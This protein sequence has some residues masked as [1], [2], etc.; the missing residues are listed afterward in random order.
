VNYDELAASLIK[1][2]KDST[3]SG[4]KLLDSQRDN[5]FA[6][7]NNAAAAEGTLYSTSGADQRSRYN[8]AKYLPQQAKLRS[9]EQTQEFKITGNLLDTKNKIDAMN[10]AAKT[11]NGIDDS[12]FNSLLV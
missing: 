9:N 10:K 12:Y 6:D 8:A 7:L 1:A 4:F 5:Y 11:L 2:L 3:Q